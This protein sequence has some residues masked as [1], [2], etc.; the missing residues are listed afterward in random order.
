VQGS[1]E[2]TDPTRSD[3]SLRNLLQLEKDIV[4]GLADRLGYTLSEAERRAILENGTQNLAAF[5]AYSRALEAEDR[6]DYQ[7]AAQYYQQAVRADPGFTQ[8]R[9][10]LSATVVATEVET[11]DPAEAPVLAGGAEVVEQQLG[12]VAEAV[13]TAEPV[14]SALTNSV[15]DLV[16]MPIEVTSAMGQGSTAGSNTNGAVGTTTAQPPPPS[17]VPPATVIGTIRIIFRLP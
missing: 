12:T 8:A 13:T 14:S 16:P 3:G 9:D 15:T 6:G 5:L 11:A 7:A 2:V 10:G 17:V 4:V 1:G